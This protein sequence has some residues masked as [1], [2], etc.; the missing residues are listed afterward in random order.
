MPRSGLSKER[1]VE[2]AVALI[3]QFGIADFSM[4]A[5]A[6]ALNIKTSSLYNHVENMEALMIEVSA[7]ALQM[8]REIELN[9]I[10]DKTKE[11][12]IMA[13]ANAYRQ[14]AKEHKELYWLIMNTAATGGEQLVGISQ[15][16]VE[17]FLKVLE[18]TTLIETEKIH[19]QRVL[20]G[21][22]HGFISQEDMGFFSHLPVNIDES[23]QIAIQCYID[24]LKQAEKRG[25]L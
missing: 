22:V 19:W 6:E 8:Q 14:F 20:R 7:Y 3:E 24:G 5:L 1:V 10:Q 15:C 18:Y 9:V 13:L 17:P 16:I 12:G 21:I 23:F 25:R 4:R 11:E 2:A